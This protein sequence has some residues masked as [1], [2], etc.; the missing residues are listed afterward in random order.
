[1][2]LAYLDDSGSRQK[3]RKFQVLT[4]VLIKDQEFFNTEL[5]IGVSLED[6][7]I[8]P[9]KLAEFEEFH[10]WELFGGYGV[11]DGVDQRLRM[12]TVEFLLKIVRSQ[13]LPIIYC[14]IDL[15]LLKSKE[16]ASANPLDMAFRLCAR[17][18]EDW[19]AKNAP[20]DFVLMIADDCGKDKVTLKN[21]FREL[22]PKRRPPDWSWG[23][24]EHVHDDMYFGDSK[25]SIG[26]QLADLCGYFI[27]KHLE[28]DPS[29]QGFYEI[30]KDQIAYAQLLPCG[31][32]EDK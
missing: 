7:V 8:P 9:E 28:G 14:A 13:E 18:I 20:D 26:I 29:G 4:A 16:Y 10:A 12:I 22:R 24:L 31:R 1:M 6:N 23:S 30:I 21:S 32:T 17:G 11:F 3:D 15:P 2:Y 5:M 19:L 25:E 27:S